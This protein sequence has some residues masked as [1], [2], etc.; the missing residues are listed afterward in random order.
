MALAWAIASAT[1]RRAI[2]WLH[3]DPA[4]AAPLASGKLAAIALATVA[5]GS[6]AA[7]EPIAALNK[8]GK[9]AAS[10]KLAERQGKVG[11]GWPAQRGGQAPMSKQQAQSAP[12]ATLLLAAG[13]M[14][15]SVRQAGA[16]RSAAASDRRASTHPSDRPRPQLT[17]TRAGCRRCGLGGHRAR[18]PVDQR[19]T[20]QRRPHDPS[21][22]PLH[23]A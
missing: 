13:W 18:R 5:I 17:P 20:D 6:A 3:G 23:R 2:S 9:R 11:G 21:R 1:L 8:P 22:G 10:R 19:D 16:L 15:G 14:N 12:A 7:L 4:T